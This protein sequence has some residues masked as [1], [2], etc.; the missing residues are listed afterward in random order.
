MG[1]LY[2]TSGSLN[3]ASGKDS[4]AADPPR[5]STE[6]G[7]SEVQHTQS[8]FQAGLR[9]GSVRLHQQAQTLDRS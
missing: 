8:H 1:E 3:A 7:H 2:G 4:V 9:M 6:Q 5:A